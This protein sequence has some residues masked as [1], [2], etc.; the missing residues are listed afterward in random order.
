MLIDT[1]EAARR[2]GITPTRVQQLLLAGRIVGGQKVGG[3][4]GLWVIDVPDD[5]P[6]TVLS[7]G[8]KAGRPRS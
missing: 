3:Q 1:H 7:S 5:Q 8:K 2:L 4:R 6:P